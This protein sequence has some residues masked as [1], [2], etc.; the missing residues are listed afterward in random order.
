MSRRR[1]AEKLTCDICAKPAVRDHRNAP[2][3]ADGTLCIRRCDCGV[4]MAFDAGLDLFVHPVPNCLTFGRLS[5]AD[6][7]AELDPVWRAE[8]EQIDSDLRAEYA[9]LSDEFFASMPPEFFGLRS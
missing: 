6:S 2:V 3:H 1:S 5:D 9:L 4:P 8:K 7:L